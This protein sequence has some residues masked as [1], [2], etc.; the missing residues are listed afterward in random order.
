MLP[1][2]FTV[3]VG[4]HDDTVTVMVAGELDLATAP[5]LADHLDAV[6]DGTAVVLDLGALTLLDSTGVALLLGAT[7][8]A[9]HEGRPL[10]ITGTPPNAR[11]VLDLCGL[12]DVLPLSGG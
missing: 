7:R 11:R 5:L 9:A 1:T 6:A 10:R 2:D 3:T 12:L 4:R 8:R